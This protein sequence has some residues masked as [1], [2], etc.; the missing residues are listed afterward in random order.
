MIFCRY[1]R[2]INKLDIIWHTNIYKNWGYNSM[3][4]CLYSPYRALNSI[5]WTNFTNHI[6]IYHISHIP[7]K[8]VG[9]YSTW[10]WSLVCMWLFTTVLILIPIPEDWYSLSSVSFR[11]L[12]GILLVYM[13]KTKF[14]KKCFKI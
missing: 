9:L 3:I 4:E 5:L 12:F 6:Y 2:H 1:G 8:Y 10:V 11:Y 14:L 7:Y 13:I